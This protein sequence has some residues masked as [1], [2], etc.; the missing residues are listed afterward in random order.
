MGGLILKMHSDDYA[1][2]RDAIVRTYLPGY[3]SERAR[4]DC[5]WQSGFNITPLYMYLN[6]SHIDTALRAV[7]QECNGK[8]ATSA[9]ILV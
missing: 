1:R 7:I 3:T 4:W 6:D 8:P 5:L 9:R 2:L